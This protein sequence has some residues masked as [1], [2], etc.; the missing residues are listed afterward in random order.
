MVIRNILM[1]RTPP[2]LWRDPIFPIHIFKVKE[3]VNYNEGDPNND[4]FQLS[5]KVSAKRLFPNYVFLDAP[6]NLQYYKP[7]PSGNR[8]GHHGL[9]YPRDGQRL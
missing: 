7:R 3:G 4:L 8:G 1:P 9:P 2:G 5:M 6:F